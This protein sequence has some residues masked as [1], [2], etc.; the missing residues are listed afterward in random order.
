MLFRSASDALGVSRLTFLDR[1]AQMEKE[2]LRWFPSFN[3]SYNVRENLIARASW[4]TSVGRPNFNQYAG[5]VSVPDPENPSPADQITVSNVGI[6]PWSAQSINVRLE[7]YLRGVG[8]FTV[9]AF[10]RDFENFFGSTT[11]TSTPEF[12]ENYGLD[13]NVYGQYPV[14]TQYNLDTTVRMQGLTVNYRQPLTFL[15]Q[16]A[17][18]ITVF[19]NGNAQRLLGTASSANFPAFIPRTANWGFSLNRGKYNLR[20]NWNYRS[21]QRR[22]AINSTATNGIEP[23]TYTWWSKRLYIDVNAEYLF[24]RRLALFASLRN[25]GDAPDDIKVYGPSTPAV[26]RFRQRIEFGSLWMFGVK[27]TF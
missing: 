7:Y 6:K 17:R 12:L 8:Q 19:A 9:G 5:G 10:R 27:G 13:P 11:L 23:G 22:A 4:S 26:A 16:W 2:Y 1:G 3:A 15:P 20:A 21:L 18:G 25:V 24:Y 14:V